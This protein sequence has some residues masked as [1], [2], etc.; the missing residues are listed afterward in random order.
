MNSEDPDEIII[1]GK[2]M[3]GASESNNKKQKIATATS[4]IV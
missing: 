4:Q 3:R 1:E 2:C